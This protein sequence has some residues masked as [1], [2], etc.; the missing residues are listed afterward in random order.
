MKTKILLFIIF[1]VSCLTTAQNYPSP[2]SGERVYDLFNK[3]SP[4]DAASIRETLYQYE[5][6]T[7]IE[8]A[9]VTLQDLGGEDEASYAQNLGNKW[10]VGE[11][12]VDNGILFVV[13]FEDRTWRIHTGKKMEIYLTDYDADEIGTT[14][15]VPAL[16]AGNPSEGIKNTVDAI[17]THLGWQS[18]PER[19]RARREE[20]EAQAQ[21]LKNIGAWIIE[22]ILGIL[23]S[24]FGWQFFK[25]LKFKREI[26]KE[27]AQLDSTLPIMI[28]MQ[29]N[30]PTWAKEAYQSIKEEFELLTS[31]YNTKKAIVLQFKD[32][33][34]SE[35]T[36]RI[37]RNTYDSMGETNSR[38]ASIANNILKYQNDA[39]IQLKQADLD[40][41]YLESLINTYQKQGFVVGND[42]KKWENSISHLYTLLSENS[43]ENAKNVFDLSNQYI[44]EITTT[45]KGIESIMRSHKTLL[46]DLPKTNSLIDSVLSNKETYEKILKEFEQKYPVSVYQN[47]VTQFGSILNTIQKVKNDCF[48]K[49]VEYNNSKDFTKISLSQTK[50]DEGVKL[51]DNIGILYKSIQDTKTFQEQAQSNYTSQRNTVESA[52]AKARSKSQD[53]DVESSTKSKISSLS[54]ELDA[55][56]KTASITLVDWISVIN[57]L[58]QLEKKANDLYQNAENE[59]DDAE[60]ARRRRRQAAAASSSSSS[61]SYSS[62]SSRSSGSFG[63]GSFGG[64]GSGGKW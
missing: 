27:L 58:K 50:Y 7:G 60:D 4:E 10:G 45:Q 36:M 43:N 33:K 35:S 56:V 12:G 57:A 52:I 11:K 30:W 20:E 26:K 59:I 5:E 51:L 9:V 22:F 55:I 29:D 48:V 25:S 13:S 21:Q 63:G 61:S 24:F 8:I 37:V 53:S 34:E 47:L 3:I 1:C 62:S 32:L 28:S 17:I 44:N 42:T 31:T 18:W 40:Y 15:L 64:G 16:Q 49:A 14:I 23:A 54:G 19:E 39:S 38:I 41:K 2:I 6:K 46:V